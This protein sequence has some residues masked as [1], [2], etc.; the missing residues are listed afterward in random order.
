MI[1]IAMVSDNVHMELFRLHEWV[2]HRLDGCFSA[3]HRAI[4]WQ[5]W[6]LVDAGKRR[7]SSSLEQTALKYGFPPPIIELILK[8]NQKKCLIVL[9]LSSYDF[10]STEYTPRHFNYFA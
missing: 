2:C 1:M 4:C 5:K 6:S 3:M 10:G 7:V 9:C 8:K